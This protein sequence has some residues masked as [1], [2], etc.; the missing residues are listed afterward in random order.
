[1]DTPSKSSMSA[2]VSARRA[3]LRLIADNEKESKVPQRPAPSS[4]HVKSQSLKIAKNASLDDAIALTL[5]SCLDHFVANQP[6]PG[7]LATVE[8]VHQMRVALRRLRA[9][10][11]LFRRAV[12]SSE[13]ETAAA[14][15]KAVATQLGAARDLDV[16]SQNL[17]TG[18]FAKFRSE[19]SFYALLD[20]IECRRRRAYENVKALLDSPQIAQ[21]VNDLRSALMRRAWTSVSPTPDVEISR[22]DS[23]RKFAI[24][25]LDRLH[26]RALNR[27]RGLASRPEHE[28]HLARIALKKVRYAVEFFQ[29]LFDNKD[30]RAYLRVAARVQDEL[31]VYNDMAVATR[32]LKEIDASNGDGVAYAAGFV[33]GWLAHAQETVAT[34]ANKN[35]KAVHKLKTFWR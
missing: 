21:F 13:L 8:Q 4:K 31:G 20:A 12:Q 5:S 7:Q 23:A 34:G 32:L 17:E 30:A 33:R 16:F 15:A 9:A 11:S 26:R 10:V 24:H 25:A 3:S 6:L 1:M 27:C 22:P 18:V 28:Q 2:R 35:Q 14:R 19:A 29:S